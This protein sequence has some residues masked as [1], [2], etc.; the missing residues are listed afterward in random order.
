MLISFVELQN[1]RKLKSIRIDFDE[2][3]R[4][5]I[6]AATAETGGYRRSGLG[7]LHGVDALVDFT[8]IK[9]IYQNVGVVGA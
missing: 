1:F 9:H 5:G 4:G 2:Q 8:E 3:H 7:R 6:G